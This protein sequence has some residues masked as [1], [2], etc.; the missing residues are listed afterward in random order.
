MARSG[1]RAVLAAA[2]VVAVS[3]CGGNADVP[4]S[5]FLGDLW[6]LER[7]SDTAQYA[8]WKKPGT[9]LKRYR[10]VLLDP[11]EVRAAAGVDAVD[12]IRTY[13]RQSTMLAMNESYPV[14]DE[15]GRDVLR[16]RAAIA[17]LGTS[18]TTVETDLRDS[19][20]GERVAAIVERPAET[21]P[22]DS[23]PDVEKTLDVWA[24]A[25]RTRLAALGGT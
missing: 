17:G 20:T 11:V 10:R 23:W 7:L 21:P 2:L 14:A 18:R 25:L 8:T 15:P 4:R 24:Q 9:D 22:L 19:L 13:F 1:A 6:R 16:L 12:R 5:E 3:A